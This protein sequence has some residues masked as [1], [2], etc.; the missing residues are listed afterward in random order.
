MRADLPE[1]S[2]FLG[3]ADC[4]CERYRLP[5]NKVVCLHDDKCTQ[6]AFI[7]DPIGAQPTHR[8]R[9]RRVSK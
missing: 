2:E 4:G 5:G 3:K 1:D 8:L 9:S 6:P 7:P